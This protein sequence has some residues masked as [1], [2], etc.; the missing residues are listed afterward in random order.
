MYRQKI[1]TLSEP[2]LIAVKGSL[3][4][5][6]GRRCLPY[7]IAE[8]VHQPILIP[9]NLP[10]QAVLQTLNRMD[11]IPLSVIATVKAIGK[12]KRY[13]KDA[14]NQ[15]E[16]SNWKA[17]RQY[18]S[19]FVSLSGAIY[20]GVS[21]SREDGTEAPHMLP[22]QIEIFNLPVD[23]FWEAMSF[24]ADAVRGIYGAAIPMLGAVNKVDSL[25]ERLGLC[26]LFEE[27]HRTMSLCV[28]STST[29]YELVLPGKLADLQREWLVIKTNVVEHLEQQCRTIKDPLRLEA[30]E[31]RLIV[32]KQNLAVLK[33]EPLT[34][35]EDLRKTL[36]EA[37]EEEM[38]PFKE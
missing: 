30:Y 18:A 20:Q 1:T 5:S 37:L 12:W 10:E 34:L 38:Q 16:W 13:K 19:P 21:G 36:D 7:K 4:T 33:S 26:A 28:A 6:T 3:R 29:P 24:Q 9:Q 35:S 22:G 17:V 27:L 11:K 25:D 31:N 8:P 32:A 14:D 15:P 23:Q 2:A